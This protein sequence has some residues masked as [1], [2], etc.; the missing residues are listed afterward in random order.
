MA[1]ARKHYTH[2][3]VTKQRETYATLVDE[4]QEMRNWQHKCYEV[5]ADVEICEVEQ[6]R[7]DIQKMSQLRVSKDL[8]PGNEALY[9]APDKK[10]TCPNI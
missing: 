1:F 2:N 6:C 5:E 8:C 10:G 9:M 4:L 7:G 3:Q